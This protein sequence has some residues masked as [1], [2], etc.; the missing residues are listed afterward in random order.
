MQLRI[1][2]PETR[3][4]LPPGE[5]GEILVAGYVTPGYYRDPENNARAFDAEGYFR[6]GDL[7]T[8]DKEGRLYFRGRLTDLIKSGGITISPLE[9]EAYLMTYPKVQYASVVGLPD[10]M[11]GEVP[12][13]VVALR[14]GEAA[15]PE[16]I[17]G[18]CRDHIASY[19]IPVHV[20]FLR[21]DEFPRTSTGKV[22]KTGLCEVIAARLRSSAAP[23]THREGAG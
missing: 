8:L 5:V 12:V 13:A 2:H 17:R 19:K 14:A 23:L 9:V 6:T 11:K 1:V 20:V 16:E 18:F 22:Q 10:A 4:V 15:T 21:M 3:A 7:G